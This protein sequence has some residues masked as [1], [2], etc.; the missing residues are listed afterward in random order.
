MIAMPAG[1]K[2]QIFGGV[3][4]ALG[5]FGAALSFGT[6][7]GMAGFDVFLIVGG[8]AVFLFGTFQKLGR[9]RSAATLRDRS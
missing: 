3:L 7:D 9:N 5:L 8:I 6:E 2:K 4:V 1:R